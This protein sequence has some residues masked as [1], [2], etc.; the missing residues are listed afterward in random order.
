MYRRTERYDDIASAG[1][2]PLFYVVTFV[3]MP[4]FEIRS[5]NGSGW[6]KG[7]HA[8][9]KLYSSDIQLHGIVI[10]SLPEKHWTEGIV[11]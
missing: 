11:Q 5:G 9:G 2:K 1:H 10:H 4:L 8:Q 3:K 7:L 6:Q